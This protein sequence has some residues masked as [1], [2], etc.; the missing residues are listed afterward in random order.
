M[1]RVRDCMG[2]GS[3]PANAQAIAGTAG[4]ITAAGSSQGASTLLSFETNFVTTASSAVGVVLPTSA[5]G[6]ANGDTCYV[7][8]NTSDTAT[9]YPGGSDTING[10]S[11]AVNVAQNKMAVIKRFTSTQ[12]GLVVTA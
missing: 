2:T 10:S 7:F 1:A 11:S 9:V 6:S 12:W 5:Q 4:A 3:A 8:C